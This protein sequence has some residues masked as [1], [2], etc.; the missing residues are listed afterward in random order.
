[1]PTGPVIAARQLEQR[2]LE[3][4][5][6]RDVRQLTWW[7]LGDPRGK[8]IDKQSTK[9]WIL[10]VIDVAGELNQQVDEPLTDTLRN[11]CVRAESLAHA[12]HAAQLDAARETAH[13]RAFPG[14]RRLP[15]RD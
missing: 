13:E 2:A 12:R 10:L 4:L 14:G 3:L 7:L 1:M 5:A 15:I 11:L 9:T 8:P 6:N